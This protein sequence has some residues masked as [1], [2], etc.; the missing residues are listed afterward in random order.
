[1]NTLEEW[2]K[3][4]VAEFGL[5]SA[6]LDQTVVL[7]IAKDVAHGVARPAAPLTTF[8]VGVAVGRGMSLSEAAVTVTAMAAGWAEGNGLQTESNHK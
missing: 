6:A 7:D 5:D 1:M 3:Q 8:L 4:V 2:T